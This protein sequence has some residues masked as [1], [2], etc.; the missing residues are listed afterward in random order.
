MSRYDQNTKTQSELK[1]Q[2]PPNGHPVQFLPGHKTQG[3]GPVHVTTQCYLPGVVPWGFLTR[4]GVSVPGP[5]R[6]EAG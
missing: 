2:E 5:N 1:M 4:T 6:T 3:F